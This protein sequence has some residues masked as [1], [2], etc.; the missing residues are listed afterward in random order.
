MAKL[1][2]TQA[3]MINVPGLELTY[4]IQNFKFIALI[5]GNAFL[6]VIHL[7]FTGSMQTKNDKRYHKVLLGHQRTMAR[8]YYL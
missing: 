2:I 3:K 8:L 4:N 7:Y 6:S 1:R 5:D